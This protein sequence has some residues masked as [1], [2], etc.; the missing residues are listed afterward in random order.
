MTEQLAKKTMVISAAV[1]LLLPH[2]LFS[3]TDTQPRKKVQKSGYTKLLVEVTEESEPAEPVGGANIRA[4]SEEV[5]A[6]F[7]METSTNS[8]GNATIPDVPQGKVFIQV[9]ANGYETY[10]KRYELS[11]DK[12]TIKVSLKKKRNY[13]DNVTFHSR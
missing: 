7:D 11:Q 3:Q 5:G 2:T 8:N 9:I 10:G 1:A 6:E 12:L 4:K 13:L